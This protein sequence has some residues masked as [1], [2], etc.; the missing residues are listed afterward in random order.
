M[1][2]NILY[3]SA[4]AMTFPP[5]SP[6]PQVNS[7]ENCRHPAQLKATFKAYHQIP[8]KISRP[9]AETLH[10]QIQDM[11]G[12]DDRKRGEMLLQKEHNLAP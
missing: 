4:S 2:A 9:H 1:F 12:T 3:T 10:S 5:L 11:T 7:A 6:P 8:T